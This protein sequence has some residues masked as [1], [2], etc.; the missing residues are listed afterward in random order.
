MACILRSTVLTLLCLLALSVAAHA[1]AFQTTTRFDTFDGVCDED[2]SLRD[3]VWAS[4]ANPGPDVILLQWPPQESGLHV[5]FLT[6][7]DEDFGATG[8]LDI[9]A[10]EE[11]TIIGSG[12][13]PTV[14]DGF[15]SF[16]N[17]RVFDVRGS[18]VLQDIIIRNGEPAGSGGG[19]R[20]SG[21][22]TL[23]NCQV[24]GNRANNFGFG[25]GIYSDGADSEL[26]LHHTVVL[27]NRAEGGGGGIAAGGRL[28]MVKAMIRGN[29]SLEDFGGGAYLFSEAQADLTNVFFIGNRAAVAGGGLYLE[30]PLFPDSRVFRNVTF[31]GNF[32]PV[33]P[34]CAGSGCPTD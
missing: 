26:T 16:S 15:G 8:D 17:D 3:A 4:N 5:L 14:I 29:Q 21:R 24:S 28:N 20:N 9:A 30:P 18:L 11:L 19:I 27:G 10:G 12:A 2:C 22:L 23:I 32:A 31:D 33:G 6:G 13:N 34:D 7:P 1:D 25:G